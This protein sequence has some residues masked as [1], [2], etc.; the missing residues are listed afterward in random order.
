M[1]L[2]DYFQYIS[3][4]P[5]KHPLFINFLDRH[6]ETV[7]EL[8]SARAKIANLERYVKILESEVKEKYGR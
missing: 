6:Y 1:S 4:L 7:G 8:W 3:P 2:F 5:K